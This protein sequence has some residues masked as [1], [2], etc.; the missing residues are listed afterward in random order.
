MKFDVKVNREVKYQVTKT[1][2]LSDE[3]ILALVD[4][5]EDKLTDAIAQIEEDQ[6]QDI[7]DLIGGVFPIMEDDEIMETAFD[8]ISDVQCHIFWECMKRWNLHYHPKN[9]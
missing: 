6:M 4:N 7:M 1:V 9:K 2:D 8:L 5:L 3:T